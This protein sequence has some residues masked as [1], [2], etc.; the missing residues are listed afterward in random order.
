M[1]CTQPA[2]TLALCGRHACKL[3]PASVRKDVA[4]VRLGH[5][6]QLRHGFGESAKDGFTLA[7]RGLDDLARDEICLQSAVGVL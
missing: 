1:K 3:D 6:D 5:P 4:A 2:V 7:Q